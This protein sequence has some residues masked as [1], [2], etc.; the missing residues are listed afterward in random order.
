M[1]YFSKFIEVFCR[2][3]VSL[4]MYKNAHTSNT[5]VRAFFRYFT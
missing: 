4:F 3:V 2:V 1:D 5:K